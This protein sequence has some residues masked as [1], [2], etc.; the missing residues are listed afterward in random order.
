MDLYILDSNLNE[1]A[2][3]DNYKSLIWATRYYTCG[4]FE[5]Y[6][7]ANKALLEYLIPD[8][9]IVRDDTDS[10]MIIE[11]IKI[12][13]SVE[14]GDFY[15][16]TGRSL[17]SILARRIVWSQTNISVSDAAQG[18]YQLVDENI[19]NPSIESRKITNFSI[20]SS[21][22]TSNPLK[23]QITGKILLDAIS[24]ICMS[25]KIGF[26]VILNERNF[27]FSCYQGEEV[28]VTFSSEYD[29][30]INSNYFYDTTNYK[31]IA[32]VAGEGEGTSRIRQVVNVGDESS[33]ITRR[34]VYVDARDVSS[35]NGEIST[36]DYLNLLSARGSEK[37]DSEYNLSK[38]FEGQIE[39]NMTYQYKTDYNLGDVVT[40]T[41]EYGI[42][43]NP[44]IIE[45]IESWDDTGYTVIPT[46]EKWE[47]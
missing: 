5:L 41:N 30:L 44:R 4:D 39:P 13:T 19:V 28:N 47:V 12:L 43:A 15:I 14:D 24:D 38:E 8:N 36:S 18:I 37:L 29:N 3:I 9:L 20:N 6:L 1:I 32:L 42:T 2:I 10:V 35:N 45:I 11:T 26:K 21:F 23:I 34:E 7:P 46:F 31:N 27:I 22:S 40:V 33:G 25:Y 16:I 17:E